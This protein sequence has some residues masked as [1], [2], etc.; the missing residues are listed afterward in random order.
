MKDPE[1]TAWTDVGV[2]AEGPV[3][4]WGRVLEGTKGYR[5]E[6]ARIIGPL[7]VR[8]GCRWP[9]TPETWLA[10]ACSEPPAMVVIDSDEYVPLCR[11]HAEVIPA[12]KVSA[13]EFM[14]LITTGLH[15][16]YGVEILDRR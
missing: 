13:D 11:Q 4:L 3:R 5:A 14:E 6:R 1:G 12:P 2:W 10:H 8:L 16:R 9:C 15:A 7:V